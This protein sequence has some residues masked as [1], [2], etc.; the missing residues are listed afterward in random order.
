MGYTIKLDTGQMS[1]PERRV[2]EQ[3]MNPNFWRDLTNR[4]QRNYYRERFEQVIKKYGLGV[5]ERVGQLIAEKV[6]ELL[7]SSEI[8]P[9]SQ[10]QNLGHFT[11]SNKGVKLPINLTPLETPTSA[12]ERL[13]KVCRT[14][15]EHRRKDAIFCEKKQCRNKDSNLRNNPKRRLKH[16]IE[17][18]ELF[19]FREVF[20]PFYTILQQQDIRDIMA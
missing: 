6:G 5:C 16:R 17:Q 20:R 12:Y 2:Y 10:N 3:G 14:P 8:L 11:T 4:K 19:D 7:P 9:D 1:R 15:I 13:C 18:T